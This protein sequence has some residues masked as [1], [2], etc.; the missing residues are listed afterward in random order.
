MNKFLKLVNFEMNR[1]KKIY[2]VL[3]LIT[4][5]FQFVGVFVISL[6]FMNDSKR[7]MHDESL[8]VVQYVHKYGLFDFTHILRSLWFFAPIGIGVTAILFYIFFIWYRDWFGKNTFI[9]RLLMLPTSRLNI[10]LSKGLTILIFVLGLIAFQLILLPI[11]NA[12][13]NWLV[14]NEFLNRM[15][16][17]E[18]LGS[19]FELSL[20][21]PGSF[22][23]FIL[24][25]ATGL[26]AVFVIFTG[27]LFERSYRIKGIIFGVLYAIAAFIVFF[28]PFLVEMILQKDYLYGI[29][30]LLLLIVMGIIVFIGS[31]L[32]SN[33]LLKKK[34][35]V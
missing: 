19:S 23:E 12:M 9:Y 2:I 3:L 32:V 33:F 28:S 20:L 14:S 25:Y 29:E 5:I 21:I 6:S 35:S 16:V 11:E 13:V 4:V 17:Q 24:Y 34:V 26:M 7:M 8:S 15:N 27:I 31:L 18:I 1:F 30:K 22:I 10:I